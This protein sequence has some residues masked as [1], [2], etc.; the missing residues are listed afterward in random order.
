M[1]RFYMLIFTSML[2][3][4]L[5]AQEEVLDIEIVEVIGITPSQG[6]GLAEEKIPFAVQ[7]ATA[8]EIADSKSVNLSEFFNRNLGSVTINEAQSNPLQPDIQYRGFTISPLLGLPQGLAVYQ[9]G[10]R[11]NEAFGDTINW[12]LIPQSAIGNIALLGGAN[13]L[14]GLNTLGGA[15]SIT[16]K[17]GFSHPGHSIELYGGS[18]E[19][20]VTTL[21][22]GGNDGTW[23]YF[24]TGNFFDED[25]WREASE[26]EALNV[27][28][29]FSRWSDKG[30]LNFDLA[31]G[32][33]ELIGNGP[34]PAQLSQIDRN[35]VFTS[36]DI[37]ENDMILLNLQGTYQFKEFIELSGNA[38]YRDNGTA[39]FNGDGT[40]FEVCQEVANLI[41]PSIVEQDR[42]I[43]YLCQ[44]EQGQEERVEDQDGNF[45]I[46][47]GEFEE[48]EFELESNNAINNIS[49][50]SQRTFGSNLQ[51]SFLQEIS[52]RDNQLLIG[53][54][55]HQGIVDFRAIVEVATLN[56]DRSTSGSGIFVPE[57]GTKIKAHTRTWSLYLS[58]TFSIT[59]TL[60]FTLSGRYNNTRVE[61]GDR[62]S[63]DPLVEEQPD[64]NGAHS[65]DRFNPSVGLAWEYLP[66][67][68]AYFSYSES[69]RAP[70][71]VELACADPEAPCSLPNAFLADPPLEQVVTSGIEGGLRG[72]WREKL[73]WH[74]G[75]F[76]S[77]N[78]QDI[79]FLSTG[80]TTSNQGFFDNV[81]T[82]R[83]LGG[84]VNFSGSWWRLKWFTNYGFTHATF[85]TPFR[86]T[87]PNHPFSGSAHPRVNGD[88]LLVRAGDRIPG[89]PQH[90]LKI[91]GDIEVTPQLVLGLNVLYNSDQ[92]LRGDEANLIAPIGDYITLNVRGDYRFSDNITFFVRFNNILNIEYE[93]FGLFGEPNEILGDEFTDRRFLSPSA[94]FS[95]F[96]GVKLNL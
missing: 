77:E 13:P 61:T 56:E 26:S 94:P 7:S 14:F 49:T 4:N 60:A 58:D 6:S 8:D 39:S 85:E 69:A 68:S 36:P 18:F 55:Y 46:A 41:D 5:F 45:I 65:F 76:F 87:S 12:D 1:S 30:S 38:Y 66:N 16:T 96:I 71:P 29:R 22:S 2:L 80:G 24:I 43:E 50:Q 57:E 54:A 93:T 37:T 89:I 48:G 75:G 79:L 62:A 10:V 20:F 34:I 28:T 9:N 64:L 53:G 81:G 63:S 51:S 86:A 78:D 52:G 44:E 25:G 88:A 31:Y 32:D 15:I 74:I 40:E 73:D 42:T 27:F 90:S 33:T 23:G 67:H 3:G 95:G 21:E 19:R 70:T 82:T 72:N 17:D 35:T 92:Y 83:R 84:E 91:G 47:E 11:L 59:D